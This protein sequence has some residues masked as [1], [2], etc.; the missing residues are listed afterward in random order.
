MG[1]NLRH[2]ATFA[3]PFLNHQV[4]ADL[5]VKNWELSTPIFGFPSP[6]LAYIPGKLSILGLLSILEL[7][8][9]LGLLSILE[10]LTLNIVVIEA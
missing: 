6:E 4:E 2:K 9:I 3:E 10:L 7:L 8:S 1:A 5:F